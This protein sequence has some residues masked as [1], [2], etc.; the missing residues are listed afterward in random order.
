[1]YDDIKKIKTGEFVSSEGYKRPKIRRSREE[2]AKRPRQSRGLLLR[3]A[4]C[5]VLLGILLFIAYT[6]MPVAKKMKKDLVGALT[7]DIDVDKSLGKLKFVQSNDSTVENVM[8]SSVAISVKMPVK[9][10]AVVSSY[11][12]ENKSV[13]LEA[14]QLTDVICPGAG[15]VENVDSDQRFVITIDHGNDIKSVLSFNG[16]MA[17]IK[18]GSVLKKGDYIGIMDKGGNLTFSMIKNGRNVNPYDYLTE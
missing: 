16:A 17:V 5:A 13:V 3:T 12:E 18:E 9:D 7:F 6:D 8:S 14:T 2:R 10:A 4:V 1:M 11:S 15:I